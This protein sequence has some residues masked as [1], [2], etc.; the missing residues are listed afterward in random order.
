M[1]DNLIPD[2]ETLPELDDQ[3]NDDFTPPEQLPELPE[4]DLP[5][6]LPRLANIFARQPDLFKAQP[7]T[8]PGEPGEDGLRL[9]LYRFNLAVRE[10]GNDNSKELG[11]V[12]GGGIGGRH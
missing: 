11:Q 10:D 9:H 3:M 6:K 5:N 1:S 7:A 4:P 8:A 2:P 12:R